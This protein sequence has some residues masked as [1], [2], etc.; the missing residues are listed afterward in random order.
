MK[1]LELATDVTVKN[2]MFATDFSPYSNAALP[3]ALGV[4]NRYKVKLSGVHVISPDMYLLAADS[5]PFAF[6]QQKEQRALDAKRFEEQLKGT[7]HSIMSPVGDTSDVIFRL[8]RDQ[9]IDLLVVGTHGRSGLPKFLL[10]S[11]AEKLFRQSPIPVLTVGPLV[12]R[13]QGSI[14][15]NKIV[16]ATDFSDESLAALPHAISLAQQYEGRLVLLRVI[17]HANSGTVNMEA[18]M[19]FVLRRL[20]NLI[21]SDVEFCVQPE[22]FVEAGIPGEKIREF[23]SKYGMDLIVLGIHA[24]SYGARALTHIG[25]TLAHQVVAYASCPVL[26]V[27]G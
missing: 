9:Q 6:E 4:A 15:F 20:K 10:G 27:R 25:N 19:E 21:P 3:Y 26:T 18:D 7:P 22:F 13:D 11:V 23:A 8:V 1:T 24:P 17:E 2:V 14:D 16:F 12:S 5:F